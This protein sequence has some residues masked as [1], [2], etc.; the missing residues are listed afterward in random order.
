VFVGGSAYLIA[1]QARSGATF[2]QYRDDVSAALGSFRSITAEERAAA[3]P[4]QVR[5]ITAD[6]GLTFAELGRRSPLGRNAEG[7]LRVLNGM[8]P[9]GEPTAGQAIKIVE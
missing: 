8:Y 9:A 2:N 5:V 3:R 1:A 4:L 7:Y 6:A